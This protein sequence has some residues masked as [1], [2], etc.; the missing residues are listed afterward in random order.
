MALLIALVARHVGLLALWAGV[1]V[2]V[3][4]TAQIALWHIAGLSHLLTVVAHCHLL[5]VFALC[6]LCSRLVVTTFAI[7]LK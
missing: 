3:E 1:G 2:V 6:H 5:T 7:R 4:L